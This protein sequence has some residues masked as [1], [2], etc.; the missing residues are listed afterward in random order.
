MIWWIAREEPLR[1]ECRHCRDGRLKYLGLWNVL[2][3]RNCLE[4]SKEEGFDHVTCDKYWFISQPYMSKDEI[5]T[6][7][8]AFDRCSL[9][10]RATTR[11]CT[12]YGISPGYHHPATTTLIVVPRSKEAVAEAIKETLEAYTATG[13]WWRFQTTKAAVK[14]LLKDY[15]PPGPETCLRTALDYLTWKD[16]RK[17]NS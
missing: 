4:Y 14:R 6:K 9:M 5:T 13:I 1:K 16:K 7:V 3:E 11:G 2:L 8:L 17:R 10:W 12:T 15:D